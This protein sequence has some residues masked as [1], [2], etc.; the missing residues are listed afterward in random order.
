MAFPLLFLNNNGQT[1]NQYQLLTSPYYWLFCFTYIALFYL[2]VYVLIP[3]IFL[4][5]KYMD[6]AVVTAVLLCGVFFLQPFDKLLRNNEN[7]YGMRYQQGRMQPPPF[8]MPLNGQQLPPPPRDGSMPPPQ[9]PPNGNGNFRQ[10]DGRRMMR[11]RH[12]DSTSI[13][14]FAMIMALSTATKTMQQ[15]QLTEQRA[16]RAEA[17]KAS[18]EL[19]FLKAQI[20]PHFLFNTLNNIYSLAVIGS[21]VTADSIMKLSN[22]MRYVTDDVT[23]DMV[24]LQ[25]EIDCISDYIELQKLR[26][27]KNTQVNFEVKGD[28]YGRQIAP[29]IMMTFVENVFKYGV[30]KNVKSVIDISIDSSEAGISFICRNQKFP[31]SKENQSTGI[32]IKNTRKRLEHLYANRYLLDIIDADDIYTVQLTLKA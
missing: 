24:P 23:A 32:G 10:D 2:N 4:K 9:G 29:L 27:S 7:R 8:G 19:S 16:A 17:D 15:W 3:R 12:F 1:T 26:I 11:R 22:I 30:S 28:I 31:I 18:A 20:N 5:K 13:F 6:Y 14:I 21:Q 25:S